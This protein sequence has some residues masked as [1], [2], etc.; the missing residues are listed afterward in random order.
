MALAS[1]PDRLAGDP[2]RRAVLAWLLG[3]GDQPPMDLAAWQ[4]RRENYHRR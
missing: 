2:Q 3:R 1:L 4:A